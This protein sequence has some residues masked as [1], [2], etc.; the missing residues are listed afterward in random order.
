MHPTTV[1]F[2]D[3]MWRMVETEA[4]EEGISASQFIRESVFARMM[5]AEA[6]R[7]ATEDWDRAI[8]EVRR[9][10]ADEE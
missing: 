4:R 2:S 3:A 1:R 8:A 6:K 5:I 10:L 7:G 9:L